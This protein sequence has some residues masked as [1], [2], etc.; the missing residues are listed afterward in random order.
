MKAKE[1]AEG[2]SG[3]GEEQAAAAPAAESAEAGA[4]IPPTAAPPPATAEEKKP[5]D[6]TK[7]EE[8]RKWQA[9]RDR[10]ETQLQQQLRTQGEQLQA[11]RRQFEEAQLKD[12]DPEQ[13]AAYYQQRAATLEQEQGTQAVQAQERQEIVTQAEVLLADLGLDPD[14]PGLEWGDEPSWGQLAR[15]AASAAKVK[16]LQVEA[17]AKEQTTVVTEAAQQARTEA[18]VQAGVTQVSTA[19]GGAT[20]TDLR[21]EFEAERQ[22]LRGSGDVGALAQLK[23]KYRKQG[24]EV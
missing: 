11:M 15:L 14:T 5:V 4:T 21:A 9:A 2:A 1:L 10:R 19:V 23:A 16:A 7:S 6:L 17:L 13:V 8:F 22:K 12:A 20:P 3:V 18:L 24:L